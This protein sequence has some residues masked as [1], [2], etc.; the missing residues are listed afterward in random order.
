M[1][2]DFHGRVLEGTAALPYGAVASYSGIAARIGAPSAVRS[3]GQALGWNPL[4]IVIPCPRV[5]GSRGG[6]VGYA[7]Q[8]VELKQ[9]QLPVGG[10]DARPAGHHGFK[11][12]RAA[13][14]TSM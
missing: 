9:R 13:T 1:R 8:R 10:G 14:S 12:N 6:L 4:P 3:V 5:I 7:G 2:S 11:V